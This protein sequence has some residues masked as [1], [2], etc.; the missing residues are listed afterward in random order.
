MN[1]VNPTPSSFTSRPSDWSVTPEV[2]GSSPV[3]PDKIPA[4]GDSLV[5]LDRR[6]AFHPALIPHQSHPPVPASQRQSP[7]IPA[8]RTP[9][10]RDPRLRVRGTL[11]RGH[12]GAS[13]GS[14]TKPP[15]V[16]HGLE[17]L[18]GRPQRLLSRRLAS[19]GRRG[20][21]RDV[22]PVRGTAR[23]GG[24]R[25]ASVHGQLGWLR[26]RGTRRAMCVHAYGRRVVLI[27]RAP[28]SHRP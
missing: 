16:T 3:A 28:D 19:R 23:S 21:A 9:G 11:A 13:P 18:S 25:P 8:R 26:G 4:K 7:R 24:D 14:P 22:H 12:C 20:G 15:P 2:A 6:L 1:R 10:R 17:E 5:R 27:A